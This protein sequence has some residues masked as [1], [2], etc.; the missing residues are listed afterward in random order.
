M[1]PTDNS[2]W[3]VLRELAL[4][5][6]PEDAE[7]ADAMSRAEELAVQKPGNPTAFVAATEALALADE[8][9]RVG[10]AL[11]VINR[12]ARSAVGSRQADQEAW[13]LVAAVAAYEKEDVVE[14]AED[15]ARQAAAMLQAQSVDIAIVESMAGPFLGP[16]HAASTSSR[17]PTT[18]P[19]LRPTW[20][21]WWCLRNS[22]S[23]RLA[24]A[25][26]SRPSS[27][28]PMTARWWR[29]QQRRSRWR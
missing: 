16:Y 27:A 29:Q 21:A 9:K 17:P 1:A 13:A 26:T 28:T 4:A 19:W 7:V 15:A 6:F 18:P 25:T 20:W 5:R 8:E 24:R 2:K 11:L 3:A 12:R 22:T 23:R 14:V 10:E